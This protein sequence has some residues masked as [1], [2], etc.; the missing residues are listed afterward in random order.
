[1]RKPGLSTPVTDR[2]CHHALIALTVSLGQLL[3]SRLSGHPPPRSSRLDCP[4]DSGQLIGDR[5][6]ARRLMSELIQSHRWPVRPQ[7]IRTSE[8]APLTS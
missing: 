1:M 8:R 2:S 5:Y 6:G 7:A 4:Y 3:S